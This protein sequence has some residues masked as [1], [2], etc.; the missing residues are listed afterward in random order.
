MFSSE[1]SVF[2]KNLRIRPKIAVHGSFCAFPYKGNVALSLL[3][4]KFIQCDTL[5]FYSS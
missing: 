2:L 1:V 4:A 5:C 3:F